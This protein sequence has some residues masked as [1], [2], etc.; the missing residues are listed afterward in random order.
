M[1]ILLLIAQGGWKFFTGPVGRWI[2]LALA[3][4][5]LL[6]GVHHHG[7]TQGRD[8][9]KASQAARMERARKD[10]AR[11]EAKA[12]HITADVGKKSE[13]RQAE[14]R[15]RTITTIREVPVYVTA[16]TDRRY[17]VPVGLVR[18]HDAAARGVSPASVP[19]PSGLADDAPSE[20]TAS[21]FG[22]AVSA[23][24]G[25]CNE[26]IEKYGALQ[27]WINQQAAAWNASPR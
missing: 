12:V 20:I 19:D 3:V 8:R 7:V 26:V 5:A 23:N 27:S 22:S 21:A 6:A 15:W 17:P 10:V 11:R 4:L 1:G 2:A 14:I 9:E 18:L 16:E 25:T 13:T 24:Y